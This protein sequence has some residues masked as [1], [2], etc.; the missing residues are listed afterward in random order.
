MILQSTAAA[1]VTLKASDESGWRTVLEVG[2]V[3]VEGQKPVDGIPLVQVMVTSRFTTPSA[4]APSAG[5]ASRSGRNAPL[6][7]MP[8]S[9]ARREKRNLVVDVRIP[10]IAT[11]LHWPES[12]NGRFVTSIDRP[13]ARGYHR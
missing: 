9:N 5:S 11:P 8:L 3:S 4:V 7:P 1:T 6:T 10:I 12:C 2:S 13:R